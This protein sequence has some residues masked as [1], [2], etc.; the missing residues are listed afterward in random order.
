MDISALLDDLVEGTER[1][2]QIE[3]HLSREINESETQ[4]AR[5]AMMEISDQI[6][7]LEVDKRM[8]DERLAQ[9][10]KEKNRLS[11]QKTRMI[12]ESLKVQLG[13]RC[14]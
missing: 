12:S 3:S 9:Y 8:A 11:A 1:L 13:N 2:E 4:Q 7:S 5:R 14:V 6:I 10:E